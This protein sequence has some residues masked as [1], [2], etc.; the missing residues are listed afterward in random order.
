M[1]YI[2][3]YLTVLF[4]FIF[5]SLIIGQKGVI[6]IQ[7]KLNDQTKANCWKHLVA[8][9]GIKCD[10]AKKEKSQACDRIMSG[11]YFLSEQGKSFF[12]DFCM[13]KGDRV[14]FVN[15]AGAKKVFRVTQK[16]IWRNAHVFASPKRCPKDTS[17]FIAECAN[18]E[19][20]S[21]K[22]ESLDREIEFQLEL[23]IERP[24]KNRKLGEYFESFN[25][26]RNIR[27]AFWHPEFKLVTHSGNYEEVDRT[28]EVFHEDIK[29][30]CNFFKNVYSN[31]NKPGHTRVWGKMYVNSFGLMAFMTDNRVLWV[32]E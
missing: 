12:G 11:D 30:G 8:I 15:S 3:S 17:Q 18:L 20:M 21:M 23:E 27:G 13:N 19:V 22:W 2:Q 1:P 16:K 5:Q 7:L 6:D 31:E 14:T 28:F 4:L 10:P 25:I 26:S 9:E 32:R 29:L 24:Y